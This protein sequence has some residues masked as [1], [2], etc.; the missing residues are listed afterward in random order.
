MA[1]C[2][3]KAMGG[4]WCQDKCQNPRD[5][6]ASPNLVKRADPLR[7]NPVVGFMSEEQAERILAEMRGTRD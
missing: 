5:C 7:N 3:A 6:S 4:K 1:K 2:I